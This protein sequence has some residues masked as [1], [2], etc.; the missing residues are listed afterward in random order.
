MILLLFSLPFY[1]VRRI[2][3]NVYQ[4]ELC[5]KSTLLYLTLY[6]SPVNRLCVYIQHI[7]SH[8]FTRPD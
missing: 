2:F 1:G 8:A 3:S 6:V 5:M 7:V 4:Y